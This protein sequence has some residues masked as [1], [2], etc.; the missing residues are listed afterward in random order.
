MDCG[1][2]KVLGQSVDSG[3]AE[4]ADG[5]L[6]SA[7]EGRGGNDGEGCN[8]FLKCFQYCLETKTHNAPTSQFIVIFVE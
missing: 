8:E 2:I 6:V 4:M 1:A 7:E 3:R 5:H